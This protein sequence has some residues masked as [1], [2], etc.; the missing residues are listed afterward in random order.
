MIRALA[1]GVVPALAV[2]LVAVWVL[3]P[4]QPLAA[5]F[6][7]ADCRRVA[8]VDAATGRALRG[9]EDVVLAPDGDTLVLAAHDRLDPSGP[10][11]AL[12][13][14]SLWSLGAGATAPARPLLGRPPGAGPFRPHGIELSPDG[15]RLAVVNRPTAGEGAIEVGTLGPDGWRPD[16][17]IR[18]GRLCRA[19]DLA[20]DP[21]SGAETLRVTLDR[22]DCATSLRDLIGGSGGI[23]R[24]EGDRLLVERTGLDFPNGIT[25]DWVAETR[26][27]RL[28]GP[29]EIPLP[30]GPDNLVPAGDRLVTA[31]HG[32]LVRTGLYLAGWLPRLSSRIV[33]VDTATGAVEVLFDDP[34]GALFSGATVGVLAGERLV[35]GSVRDFGLLFCEAPG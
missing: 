34:S 30:G 12:Y 21:P 9:A 32:N 16:R 26:A 22:A 5:R 13:A 15:T 4:P 14:V 18:D 1:A 19:N 35:A 31:L 23:A 28:L 2:V 33:A 24:I 20:F 6:A 27:R 17:V 7:A 11:G 8:L 25:A 10:D 29:F 3:M